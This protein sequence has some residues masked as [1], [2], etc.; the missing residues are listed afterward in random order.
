MFQLWWTN[1]DLARQ[2]HTSCHQRFPL[3]HVILSLDLANEFVVLNLLFLRSM[4][5]AFFQI[6]LVL[7]SFGVI[8]CSCNFLVEFLLLF[9]FL[10]ISLASILD[11]LL[12]HFSGVLCDLL[13]NLLPLLLLSSFWFL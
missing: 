7:D 6:C 10:L 3:D 4:F 2:R 5:L 8:G 9:C 11:F 1:D 12:F 13:G